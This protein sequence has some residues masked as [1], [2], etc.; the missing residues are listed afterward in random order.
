MKYKSG[1]CSRALCR[2]GCLEWIPT[3]GSQYVHNASVRGIPYMTEENIRV[4][5]CLPESDR[6]MVSQ[7]ESEVG[8][9]YGSAL[10]SGFYSST[11]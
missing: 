10:A 7:I 3:P 9:R 2:W 4:I 1:S 5:R 6:L 11:Y 8:I